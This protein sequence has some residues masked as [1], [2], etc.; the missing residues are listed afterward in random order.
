M[1]GTPLPSANRPPANSK[2]PPFGTFKKIH[3]WP[4]DP[5][6]F[7]KAPLAPIYT[8]F[9][10]ERAP[11]NAI[12]CQNFPKS[13]RK[14]LLYLFFFKV[15]MRLKKLAKTASF[16]FF[17]RARK[18]NLVNLKKVVKIFEILL[19]IRSPTPRENP[20]SAPDYLFFLPKSNLR[21][22]Y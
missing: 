8:N 17:R 21:I 2:G 11:K 18:I 14:R 1:G 5:K 20:R 15:C 12:F 13:T 3:F 9:E 7:L 16:Q 22:T 19:K 10:G 4:I 6:I